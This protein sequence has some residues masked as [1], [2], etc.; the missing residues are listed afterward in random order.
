[1]LK[2]KTVIM[3]KNCDDSDGYNGDGDVIVSL[4]FDVIVLYE[5]GD[6]LKVIK[7]VGKVMVTTSDMM[8][9]LT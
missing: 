4:T 9:K 8:M 1:M 5:N 6:N 7:M 2:S 3:W